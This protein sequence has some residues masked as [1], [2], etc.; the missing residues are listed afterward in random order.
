MRSEL[1][2]SSSQE[3]YDYYAKASQQESALQRFR[4]IQ[5]CAFRVLERTHHARGPLEIADIGCGAGT[6]SMIWAE[7]GHR[8]HGLDVN[9]P[10]LKLAEDRSA[11]LGYKIDFRLGS[12]TR[13]PWPD[14]TMDVCLELE[15]LEHVA[16]WRSCLSEASR[17]LRPGGILVLTTTN[18]LCPV[19]DEFSLPL[20]SWY[21]GRLK[22]YLERLATTTR[23]EIANYAKYPAVNWFTFYSLRA[24]LGARGLRAFD[25][26]DVMDVSS[27]S[28]MT[29][30]I[31]TAIRS[32][33]MVR[34][35]AHV[36]S[37]STLV[38]A[39]KGTGEANDDE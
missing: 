14:E 25:R 1:D 33:P 31:V 4:S 30:M 9:E 20:Y 8:V 2:H 37:R 10:L 36:A 15:L 3:F 16:D 29:R 27:K 5:R 13:L 35:L 7:L 23:P 19:Q 24:D 12:A 6:Q 21:P 26:F 38:V 17:V 39:V 22:R 34:W 18:K 28:G 11:G 32:V